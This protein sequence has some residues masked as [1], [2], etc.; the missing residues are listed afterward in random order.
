[1][2][3]ATKDGIYFRIRHAEER[4]GPIVSTHEALGVALE[5]FSELQEQIHANNSL[6]VRA[7]ALDL[8]AIMIRL[9][10][11]IENESAIFM[12]RSFPK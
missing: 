8:A 9:A 3:D 1:M 10:E 12:Q 6:V 4:F 2:T 5:E 7:E 11:A